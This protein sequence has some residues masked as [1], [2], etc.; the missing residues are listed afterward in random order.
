MVS[1]PVCMLTAFSCSTAAVLAFSFS[2]Q[3]CRYFLRAY[4]TY[5]TRS[6]SNNPLTAKLHI[7]TVEASLH[8]SM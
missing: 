8:A 4:R 6:H 1:R 5:I 3:G 2:T 7:T